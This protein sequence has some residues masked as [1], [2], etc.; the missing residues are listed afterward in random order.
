MDRFA[1]HPIVPIAAADKPKIGKSTT[2]RPST[3]M[4]PACQD[5]AL[6]GG[7]PILLF[8]RRSH[9]EMV[10]VILGHISETAS[11]VLSQRFTGPKSPW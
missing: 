3:T 2:A 6:L 4:I 9:H 10:P 11:S 1:I 5:C 8:G 7:T